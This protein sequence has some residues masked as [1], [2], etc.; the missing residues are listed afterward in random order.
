MKFIR[1]SARI[2]FASVPTFVIGFIT[3]VLS[4][5]DLPQR[6]GSIWFIIIPSSIVFAL[7]F[8]ALRGLVTGLDP[9]PETGKPFAFPKEKDVKVFGVSSFAEASKRNHDGIPIGG[10]ILHDASLI[11]NPKELAASKHRRYVIFRGSM[12]GESA[13]SRY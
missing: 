2:L 7:F 11:A 5:S 3:W 13:E 6:G 1:M 9:K 10:V 8:A 12:L 4:R